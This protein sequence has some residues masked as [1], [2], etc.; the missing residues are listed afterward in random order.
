VGTLPVMAAKYVGGMHTDRDQPGSGR[1]AFRPVDPVQQRAALRFLTQD[2][3][4]IRAAY[5]EVKEGGLLSI[6]VDEAR[7]GKLMAPLFGRPPHGEGN[8]AIAAKLA[9]R[10]GCSIV[11]AYVTRLPQQRFR[12]T[13]SDVIEMPKES[14]GLLEDVAFLNSVIEPVILEH[15]EQWFWLDDSF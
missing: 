15:L 10:S 1:A 5:R 12:V 6:F 7:E 8:L 13:I 11:L 14:K 2:H 9:R 4:G 3:G